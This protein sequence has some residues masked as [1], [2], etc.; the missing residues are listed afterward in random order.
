[1]VSKTKAIGMLGLSAFPVVVEIDI[2]NG[3][4]LFEIIGSADNVVKESRERVKSALRA[5][6]LL[7]PPKRVIVSLVPS[8]I[9]KSGSLFDLSIF[10]GLLKCM[11]KLNADHANSYFVGEIALDG[12]IHSVNGILPMTLEARK[13]GM[14]E[15][16]VPHEN[17]YEASVV[18]GVNI[19]PIHDVVELV[20]HLNG[21]RLITPQS[22]YIP[23]D[24]FSAELD[25]ADVKGQENAKYALEVAAAGGHNALLIG[26]PGSGKSMLA[27]RLP[28]ILPQMT[29]EESIEVTKILSI[30]G[31]LNKETPLVTERPFRNSHHSISDAGLVGGGSPPSPGDI[32]LAHN[33]V[34]FLDELA[35]FNNK[36]LETLRQPLE[37]QKITITRSKYS[38]E[39]PCSV[40]LIAAM[41]PCQCGFFGH[42]TKKCTCTKEKVHRYLAKISGPLLDRF[43][44]HV[45]VN[46]VKYKDISSKEKSESSADIRKRVINARAIQQERFKGTDITCNARITDNLLHEFCIVDNSAEKLLEK[47]FNEMN[48]SARAYNRILKVARTMA[49]LESSD[50]ITKKHIFQAT[51]YRSLDKKYWN[52]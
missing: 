34:L 31:K 27:M 48:L 1:M 10:I 4:P 47:F 2:N 39:Y 41:N 43:D 46:D 7:I 24:T 14:T 25:Y 13:Q 5:L 37:Q 21:E 32:S 29:F 9:K 15:I 3:M 52:G 44:M 6:N 36:T 30:V 26:A 23:K 40:M 20:R 8:D 28:S 12:K 35:E 45:E 11:G 19:Y 51:N 33:G 49:D 16:F 42:P 50:I 22:Q 38:I 17:A 18:E